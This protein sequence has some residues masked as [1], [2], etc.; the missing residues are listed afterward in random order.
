MSPSRSAHALLLRPWA[1]GALALLVLNDH[2]LKA[3]WPGAVTGK[4][5]DVAGLIAFPAL[6]HDLWLWCGPRASGEQR[7]RRLWLAVLATALTFAAAKTWAPA[8]SACRLAVGALRWPARAVLTG[9]VRAPFVQVALRQDVTDLLAL[10]FALLA[11]FPSRRFS[12]AS[13]PWKRPPSS[14][15]AAV[16]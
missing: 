8:N 15:S 14:K 2:W 12:S 7:R 11:T 10:P 4:L 13:S 1:L 16:A 5:S 3:A 6:L 9:D